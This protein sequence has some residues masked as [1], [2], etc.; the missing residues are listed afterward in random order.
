MHTKVPF[1]D[2]FIDDLELEAAVNYIFELKKQKSLDIVNLNL[3]QFV[4]SQDDREH[5]LRIKSADLIIADGAAISLSSRLFCGKKISKLAGIDLAQ[6]L[7]TKSARIVLIG[8]TQ[9]VISR[10]NNLHGSKIVYSHHGFFK[11]EQ[12][13]EIIEQ[14][15]SSKPDLVLVAMGIPKQEILIENIK[16]DLPSKSNCILMGVGGSFDIWAGKLKRAPA[17]MIFCGLEWLFRLI[18]EPYRIKGFLYKVARFLLLLTV[19]GHRRGDKWQK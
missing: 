19:G 11:A 10:L 1:F 12:K 2:L 7:I 6:A 14:I 17:W 9:E 5:N 16:K 15:I 18:Q 8:A 3:E 4:L 13:T